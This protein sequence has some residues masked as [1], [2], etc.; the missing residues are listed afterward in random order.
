MIKEPIAGEQLKTKVISCDYFLTENY[1][2]TSLEQRIDNF[3]NFQSIVVIDIQFSSVIIPED[4]G[5]GYCVPSFVQKNAMIIYREI[6][7]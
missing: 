3:I 6:K 5:Y 4:K 7:L 1:G 2:W